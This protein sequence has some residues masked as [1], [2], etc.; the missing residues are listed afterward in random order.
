MKRLRFL[1]VVAVL[2]AVVYACS[3]CGDQHYCSFDN[4]EIIKAATCDTHGQ[5]KRYC[6]CGSYEIFDIAPTHN[7]SGDVCTIC[8]R[9]KPTTDLEYISNEDGTCTVKINWDKKDSVTTLVIPD[10]SPDG[11]R[12]THISESAFSSCDNLKS[13][14]IPDSVTHI[15]ELAFYNMKSLEHLTLGSGIVEVSDA[16]S[17]YDGSKLKTICIRNL[18]AWIEN[19][20]GNKLS[21]YLNNTDVVDE[22]GNVIE[23]IVI[24]AGITEIPKSCFNKLGMSIVQLPD[25]I[26]TIEKFAFEN[27]LNLK[28]INIPTSVTAINDYAFARCSSLKSIEF[29]GTVKTIGSEAFKECTGLESV[30][31]NNGV[32]KIYSYAFYS[33]TSLKSIEMPESVS[34]MGDYVF[35]K[36]ESLRIAKIGLKEISAHAFEDCLFLSE[37]IL[38]DYVE[39]IENSAFKNCIRL[40]TIYL[41][42]G[43]AYIKDFSFYACK[44]IKNIYYSGTDEDLKY[45]I[46]E[47]LKGTVL[48]ATPQPTYNI[49]DK[50]N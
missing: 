16:F 8:N 46:N 4:S 44:N 17:N 33:C 48:C 21:D 14:V 9:S 12:V 35:S 29:P 30:V 42:K 23:K 5:G 10:Q 22:S 36:C 18:K 28:A 19:D 41:G 32:E 50:F 37:V 13:V 31:I 2:L 15:N 27:C 20:F 47:D 39:T 43:L 6:E 49:H 1:Y 24:P 40:E 26:T 25:G 38:T 7:Y 34:Y 3:S 45:I 11:E